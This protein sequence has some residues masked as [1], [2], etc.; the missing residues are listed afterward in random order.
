MKFLAQLQ[1][2]PREFTAIPFWF[3]NGELTA[4]EL[5]RQLADFAAHGIYGVVLHPRMGL[6]PDI[7]YLGERYFAHIRTAVEAAAALDMKIVLYD[8]GMYP[9]GSASGLVVKDHPELASEGITLTQTV[10]PGDELLAQ[11]ES[12]TLVVRKSGGTMRGLHW[13][14]DDGEKNAPKTADILNPAAVSRFIELTHEAYYRELK[15]YFGAAIIGFFTDEPSILGRNV[16]GMFPWTHGFAEIFRHAGGNAANLTAL[17]DGRENDDTRLYHK[18]LLQREG[19]VYYGTLSRWCEAH[20]IGLM[21]HP[22]QSDDIEVEKYFAVPG[23]DLVLRWLAPEKD[24]LAGMDSTMAKCSADAARLMHRRRNANECFG[25]CNKDDNPWQ[26]SGGDIKWYTDWLAVRGVN[27]FIPHAF[28]YSIRGKRKDERPPDVGPH[29]IWW[30][31]YDAWSTYWRGLSWLMTDI[32][33]HAEAAVLCRNRDLCPDTVRPL[34]ERQI[35]FQYIPESYFP[36][37]T[38][39]DGAL[40]L[41]GHRYTAVLGDKALFPDAAHPEVSALEPDCRCDPPQPMLR[42]ASFNKEGRACW[43]LVNEGNTPIKT[44]LTL[45]VDAPLCRYDLWSGQP[46]ACPAERTAKGACLPLELPGIVGTTDVAIAP[47]VSSGRAAKLILRRWAKEFGRTADFVVIEGCK[48]G[49]HLGFAE[50]DLLAGKC[51]TLDDILPEVLA[52]VKP[53]EAQ[54]GHSIPVF[55]AGG[56]YTGA[57]MAHFTA[58]GA[59]GVQLAT[60]FITTYECDA[61]QG[62]KDVLLNARP[63]DVRIIHSPVGMPGRALNTP[64]VQA[65]AEGTRFPPRHCARCLKTCDPAKVPYCITHA[66]IEA[67]KGNLE[68][69]LFFCGAN[70]GRLDRM[71]TVRELMDELVTEWRQ[72]R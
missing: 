51:Q 3:L 59:A 45:P 24:G 57:D 22:H 34:F 43:L 53:F 2:P 10:L 15:E 41:H 42:C 14:E 25:A 16:S 27:L 33:L 48:A 61:S 63:E 9:S 35:G 8:E 21:G 69:G 39:E 1:N 52:E 58:M 30:A 65:L 26:L 44:R 54:F 40:W 37:C 11:A 62:Y 28:Y 32:D 20:G 31:H 17:F 64:L 18:L 66:L 38:V 4:E 12:G 70:V 5:R 67:V 6:S 23:Q 46:C 36:A 60:R 47:I 71:Y 7:T 19:E 50:D 68:E 72:N 29:S 13:G 49:G 55:V 56:V